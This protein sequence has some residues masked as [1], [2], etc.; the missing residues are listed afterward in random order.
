MG[1]SGIWFRKNNALLPKD[2][3]ASGASAA[4]FLGGVLLENE[5]I[6]ENTYAAKMTTFEYPNPNELLP[7]SHRDLYILVHLLW[8]LHFHHLWVKTI[9]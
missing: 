2:I 5:P 9:D 3:W 4:G 8:G 1:A 7:K 6:G